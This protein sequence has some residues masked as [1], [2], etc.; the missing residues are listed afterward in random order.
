M[1]AQDAF[2][3][4]LRQRFDAVSGGMK[5]IGSFHLDWASPDFVDSAIT[6]WQVDRWVKIRRAMRPSVRWRGECAPARFGIGGW[7]RSGNSLRWRRFQRI[8]ATALGRCA[9]RLW[10]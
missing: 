7:K 2:S 9:W 4:H 8:G 10:I 5:A 1:V 3:G 6:V